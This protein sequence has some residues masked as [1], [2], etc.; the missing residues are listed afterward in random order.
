MDVDLGFFEILQA[1]WEFFFGFSPE[2]VQ[3]TLLVALGLM[4]AVIGLKL[5]K[6]LKDL[7]WPF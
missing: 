4:I 6:F 1:V 3:A 7:L 2:W 5:L